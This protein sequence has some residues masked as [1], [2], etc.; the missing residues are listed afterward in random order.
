MTCVTFGSPRVGNAAFAA[1]FD[2]A[3]GA[4]ASVRVVND[5]DAVTMRPWWGYVHVG[6]KRR[7]AH[8]DKG[9]AGLLARFFGSV[10]DHMLDAYRVIT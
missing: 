6:G 10:R 2:A 9:V 4:G 7:C 1:A 5:C 3:L 8:G